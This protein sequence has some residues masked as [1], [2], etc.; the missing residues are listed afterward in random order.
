MR[1]SDGGALEE[2]G[3]RRCGGASRSAGLRVSA[4]HSKGTEDG[5]VPEVEGSRPRGAQPVSVF[6]RA[7]KSAMIGAAASQ[8]LTVNVGWMAAAARLDPSASG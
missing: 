4:Q 5:H 3:R 2:E 7:T 8:S 1:A 6:V